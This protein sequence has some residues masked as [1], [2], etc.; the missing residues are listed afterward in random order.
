MARHASTRCP[1]CGASLCGPS[2]CSWCRTSKQTGRQVSTYSGGATGSH[3]T[4]IATGYSTATQSKNASESASLGIGLPKT[5][6]DYSKK[7]SALGSRYTPVYLALAALGLIACS[8]AAFDVAALTTG[9]SDGQETSVPDSEALDGQGDSRGGD[10]GPDVE[11]D[12]GDGGDAAESEHGDVQDTGSDS[13]VFADSGPSTDS[14]TD[15]GSDAPA[16]TSP[17]CARY[18]AGAGTLPL[19]STCLTDGDCCSTNCMGGSCK[20]P[21]GA[22]P[23][24]WCGA[25]DEWCPAGPTTVHCVP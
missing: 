1:Q 22:C 24:C 19:G 17:L 4:T 15:L 23:G 7:Y 13:G 11:A 9:D 12:A 21:E 8:D 18:C 10:R 25:P 2:W 5:S 14:G 20:P 6:A 3:P 16:D